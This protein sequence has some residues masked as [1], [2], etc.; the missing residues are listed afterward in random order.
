MPGLAASRKCQALETAAQQVRVVLLS[1]YLS[2]RWCIAVNLSGVLLSIY[3]SLSAYS[4]QS[5]QCITVD[6]MMQSIHMMQSTTV[7]LS[8]LSLSGISVSNTAH[9]HTAAESRRG[10]SKRASGA[11]EQVYPISKI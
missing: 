7:D 6:L 5:L 11:T 2:D 9:T 10:D 3:L 8:P 1:I 4:C